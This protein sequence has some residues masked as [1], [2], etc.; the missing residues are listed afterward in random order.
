MRVALVK[1][2]KCI[3]CGR[4]ISVCPFNA[5]KMDNEKAIIL[6]DMC[7]GCMRCAPACPT[8]SIVVK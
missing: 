4:C 1:E 7:R 6:E 5:I 2:E 8:N 3:G